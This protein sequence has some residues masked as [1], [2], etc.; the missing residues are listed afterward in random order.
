MNI[1]VWFCLLPIRI[2]CTIEYIL[3]WCLFGWVALFTDGSNKIMFY[4][5]G[6]DIKDIWRLE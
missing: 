6:N 2:I 4:N 3:F 5:I 1:F